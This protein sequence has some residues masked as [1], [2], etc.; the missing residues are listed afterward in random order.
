M[1]LHPECDGAAIGQTTF[2]DFERFCEWIGELEG[3]GGYLNLGSA[4]ILP[5]IFLKA[6]AIARNKNHSFHDFFT[7]NFDFIRHYRPSQSV[8]NRPGLLGARTY[9]LIGHHE[10]MVPLLT[11]AVLE[12]IRPSSSK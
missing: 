9:S 12:K 6:L 2:R 11:L 7:A 5:E 1:A 3:G 4:V 10:I 8:I